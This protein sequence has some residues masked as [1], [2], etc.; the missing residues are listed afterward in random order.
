MQMDSG[1]LLYFQHLYCGFVPLPFYLSTLQTQ[2]L[3]QRG[4]KPFPRS[5]QASASLQ[6]SPPC[7]VLTFCSLANSP[8]YLSSP[9]VWLLPIFWPLPKPSQPLPGLHDLHLLPLS[10]EL[11][12]HIYFFILL[13]DGTSSLGLCWA[14][15]SE[16]LVPTSLCFLCLCQGSLLSPTSHRPSFYGAAGLERLVK[17]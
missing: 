1:K 8:K 10:A 3:V 12:S 4:G 16:L 5:P 9:S 15:S 13:A 7:M 11:D 2:R 6:L 14:L 17:Y